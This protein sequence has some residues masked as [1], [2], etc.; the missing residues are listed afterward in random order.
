MALDINSLLCEEHDEEKK[1]LKESVLNYYFF[2]YRLFNYEDGAYNNDLEPLQLFDDP[3][4][5]E[6]IPQYTQKQFLRKAW[7]DLAKKD[8]SAWLG[9]SERMISN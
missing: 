8:I 2:D 3:V 4:G 5:E 9:R 6:I 1:S 7:I